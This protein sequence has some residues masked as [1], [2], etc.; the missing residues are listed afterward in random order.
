MPCDMPLSMENAPHTAESMLAT[1][2]MQ[3]DAIDAELVRLLTARADI[4]G[5][6]KKLKDANWPAACHIRHGREA[7]MHAAMFKRFASSAL[8]AQA[9]AE[10]WRLII[11]ASTMIESPLNIITLTETHADAQCYFSALANYHVVDSL[12]ALTENYTRLP[13]AILC[14]SAPLD[15]RYVTFFQNHPTLRIF[16]YAPLVLKNSA[17]PE[18]YFAAEIISELSGDDISY[19]IHNGAII[20]LDGF[21]ETHPDFP[22][23]RFI[24]AHGNPLSLATS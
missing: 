18:A 13:G 19:F 3:I 15:A 9:G 7:Q 5:N 14:L 8:G 1:Y 4:V 21:Y 17:S 22:E 20:S 2:R 24:G 12:E 6:V 23:A 16:A 10:F 11:S